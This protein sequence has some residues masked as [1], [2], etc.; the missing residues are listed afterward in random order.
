MGTIQL[1]A[2]LS[3]PLFDRVGPAG[4][5]ALR[6]ALAALVLWP[7]ARPRIR[8]RTPADLAAATALGVCS[9][10]VTLTFFEAIARIPLGVAVTIEFLGPLGVALAGSRRARDVGWVVLAAAGVAMLTLG[11]GAGESLA[12]AGIALSGAAAVCWAGYILLAKRVGAWWPG[13]EGLSVSL[14]VAALVTLPFGVAGGGAELLDPEVLV[15]SLGL[16][17][18]I[19]LLPYVME[20]IALRRLPTGLFGVIMSLE[21][22]IA[23][24]LG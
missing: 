14:V 18:L 19:P 20:L 9:G 16:A 4:V 1:G 11:K 12:V 3:E 7:F 8:G 10:L 22:G 24:L 6:L 17:L 15:A 5:V 23:A 21:P 2:A 13:L